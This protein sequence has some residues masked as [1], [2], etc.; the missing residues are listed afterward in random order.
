MR[1]VRGGI[2]AVVN[3]YFIIRVECSERCLGGG[4]G[5]GSMGLYEGCSSDERGRGDIC[6]SRRFSDLD[7]LLRLDRRE[8]RP[9]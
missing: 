1:C 2:P 4:C 8:R 6:L 3:L 9:R 5:R 7:D